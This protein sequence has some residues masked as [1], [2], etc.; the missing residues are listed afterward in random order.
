MHDP[1][2]MSSYEGVPV[3]RIFEE[4]DSAVPESLFCAA[5]RVAA[6][7]GIHRLAADPDS[8]GDVIT[9]LVRPRQRSPNNNEWAH[10]QADHLMLRM[11]QVIVDRVHAT[12]GNDPPAVF[13]GWLVVRPEDV[14]HRHR[15]FRMYIIRRLKRSRSLLQR[16]LYYTLLYYLVH[17]DQDDVEIRL[18]Y[19]DVAIPLPEEATGHRYFSYTKRRVFGPSAPV[20]DT[21]EED[22]PAAPVGSIVHIHHDCLFK[23]AHVALK[24]FIGTMQ[25]VDVEA[26]FAVAK[27]LRGLVASRSFDW[28]AV[29][30]PDHQGILISA[31]G[32]YRLLL[33]R[34]STRQR[35]EN[36]M[37]LDG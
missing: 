31:P 27:L 10:V 11:M 25:D 29:T 17:R 6:V 37:F 18:R 5:K 21:D 30:A 14:S 28:H 1:F 36:L 7:H 15:I 35:L 20:M 22:E 12:S 4:I 13:D 19:P 32:A 9:H 23:T 24:F 8:R 34:L 26:V 16:T 33:P 2:V 3:A